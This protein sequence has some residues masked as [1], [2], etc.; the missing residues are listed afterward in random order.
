[1][2][3]AH[4]SHVAALANAVKASGVVVRLEPPEWLKVLKRTDS[5]LVVIAR[6]GVF[7]RSY[8]YLTAYRGLAFY[9]TSEQPLVLPG[10]TELINAKSISIPD[11]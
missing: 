9:T 7:R 11:V 5:P 3:G 2:A 6:G 10:R 1:M 4:A 8:R